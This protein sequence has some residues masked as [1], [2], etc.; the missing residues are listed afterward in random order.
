MENN[1][2][3]DKPPVGSFFRL[4][5]SYRRKDYDTSNKIL[6]LSQPLHT[7][8]TNEELQQTLSDPSGEGICGINS[9][10]AK[11]MY[12][13]Q[14]CNR[15]FTTKSG[16][17][18]HLNY[19]QTKMTSISTTEREDNAMQAK[20]VNVD[21]SFENAVKDSY[22]KMTVWRRNLFTL[23]KGKWGKEFLQE[24]TNNIQ[25]WC[26]KTSQ[27]NISVKCIMIMPNLLLQQTSF[28]AKSSENKKTLERRLQMW[29]QEKISELTAEC[30]TLQSKLDTPNK[31]RNTED[32]SKV[33]NKLMFQGKI[34]PALRLL[35]ETGNNGIL[36]LTINTMQDLHLKHPVARPLYD[37]LL[38]QGPV[39]S[40]KSSSF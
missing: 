5:P 35:S 24:M 28:K 20:Y 16:R 33:F 12:R 14:L 15:D 26:T 18:N 10:N 37:Q 21:T 11:Q 39:Q 25:R 40:I 17:S 1:K 3:D 19:C 38:L 29:R 4:D 2:T 6:P 7:A 36:P 34:N 13:C 31:S 23:P 8:V 22:E 32:I 27:R 30:L 9:D